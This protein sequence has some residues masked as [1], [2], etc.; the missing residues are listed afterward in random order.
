MDNQPKYE[1]LEATAFF[2]DGKAS[3]QLVPGTVPRGFVTEGEDSYD[4][5]Y[6]LGVVDGEPADS[7][8]E[9]VLADWDSR[10][11]LERGRDRFHIFC[12]PCHSALGNGNGI[13]PQRGYPYPPTF[14]KPELRNQPP[15][16]FY[17]VITDGKGRMPEYGKQIPIEDR[18]AIVAYIQA[19]QL[20]QYALVEELPE[21]DRRAL[22][23][24]PLE[25]PRLHDPLKSGRE[26]QQQV[27]PS[28]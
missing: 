9:R 19:L 15:G 10:R 14:H 18:W 24:I 22:E 8:P 2:A 3:R 27:P 26:A 21:Q 13:V 11:L 4:E 5:H 6:V 25:P 7:F 12:V 28:D 17:R 1:P 16:Y 23:Q 20:S